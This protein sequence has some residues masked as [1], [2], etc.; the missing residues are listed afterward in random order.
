MNMQIKDLDIHEEAKQILSAFVDTLNEPQELAVH[1]GLLER[2]SIVVASPTASGKTLIAEMA[3]LKN[4]YAGGKTLYLVPLK[5]L[6]SEK[7]A[8]FTEKY[9]NIMKIALSLGDY[10]TDSKWLERYDVIITSNEKADS[11]LRH[12]TA[13]LN[14][15]NLVIADEIHMIDD[16]SRGPTLEIVLTT[17]RTQQ[18]H[19]LALSATISNAAEIAKW[20]GAELVESNYR[21]VKLYKGVYYPTTLDIEEKDAIQFNT[22][23]DS[24]IVLAKHALEKGKQS[25]VFVASRRSAEA[26][27]EKISTAIAAKLPANEKIELEKIAKKAL[28]TLSPPTQQCK[29]LAACIAR[30]TAFHHAGLVAAQR[31]LIENA[32]KAGLIKT[33]TATPTLCLDKEC[34]IWNGMSEI[35]VHEAK[36]HCVLALRSRNIKEVPILEITSMKSPKKMIKISSV[37]GNTITVTPNHKMLVKRKGLINNLDAEL[38]RKGDKIAT[39]GKINV[40]CFRNP[41]WSDFIKDNKN[42]FGDKELDEDVFYMI[43]VFLGDGYSGAELRNGKILYKGSPSIVGRDNDIQKRI[44][45]ICVSNGISYNETINSYG[46]PQTVLTK[47]RWFR[48][49]L[50]KVGVDKGLKKHVDSLLMKADKRKLSNL[51]KGVFDT[52][53]CVETRGG[54]SFSNTSEKFINDVKKILLLFGIVSFLRTKKPGTIKFR[55]KTYETKKAFE[56]C[57]FNSNGIIAFEKNIGFHA[58]R[59]QKSL[60]KI[61]NNITSHVLSVS[62][63]NCNYAFSPGFINPRTKQQKCWSGQRLE[64]IEYLGKNGEK[65]SSDIRK[66]LGFQP[67]KKERRLN[68]HFYLIDRR[69]SGNSVFW[70]LNKIGKWLFLQLQIKNKKNTTWFLERNDCPLCGNS[71]KKTR[72]ENWRKYDFE[73]DIFWDIIKSVKVVESSSDRVYDVVL[74]DDGSNDHHFVS[75]GFIVHNSYGM[76]LP[77]WRVVVRD[78]KRFTG[79]G[80]EPLSIMEIQQMCGRAGRPKYDKEGEAVLVAS[81]R[82]EAE[83]LRDRYIYGETE[84]IYSKLSAEPV[85]RTHVLA[86][87]ASQRTENE[88]ELESFFSKTFFAHQYSDLS[89]VM[90]RVTKTMELL[91][92]LGFIERRGPLTNEEFVSALNLETSKLA[93]TPLG[94]RVAELYIDPLSAAIMLEEMKKEQDELGTLITICRCMEMKPLLYVKKSDYF[95]EDALLHRKD[96]PDE[97]SY[98]YD[99][100]AAATKTA[101]MLE[102]WCDEHTEQYLNEKYNI[103]PGELYTKTQNAEWLL[104]SA[105]ELARLSALPSMAN[106]YRKMQVRVKSGVKE[107]LLKLIQLRGIGRGRAR[108]LFKNNIRSIIDIK[109]ASMTTLQKIL[110]SAKLAE[111]IKKQCDEDFMKQMAAIK[112][113]G[114]HKS[115]G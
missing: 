110:G 55:K 7:H 81:S 54:I 75:N 62:C 66:D 35:K 56:L 29:R 17:L 113:K 103:T 46:V 38:C 23:E 112:N 105:A 82:Q 40:D 58:E 111:S 18:P 95:V 41:K 104:F 21:P 64:I 115:L 26:A 28:S 22:K 14:D 69:H 48:E 2:K 1:A 43:G 39:V 31:S 87:I 60:E 44:K 61:V 68:S 109:K 33:L 72:R 8:E 34:F 77:A 86:L 99:D 106:H 73:G 11:L 74:A 4:F 13:W 27:A 57:I 79:N 19:I 90:K 24:E 97:W 6:G 9:G 37:C 71:V 49:F 15:I 93:A 78:T 63:E 89:E 25:L 50:L 85:L 94:K 96:V 12:G 59:K 36:N 16:V 88:K 32:F 107:E 100:F 30:G 91:E 67:W 114:K 80:S 52:D 98:E 70:K 102:D 3:M 5:A 20:L 51:L 76:N 92:S 42:P 101:L 47:S 65:R 108:L 45:D 83:K 53:G 84:P 10:D